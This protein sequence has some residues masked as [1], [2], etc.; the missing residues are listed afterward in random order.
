MY[1]LKMPDKNHAR[2][3]ELMIHTANPTKTNF[4]VKIYVR[5]IL[6]FLGNQIFCILLQQKNKMWGI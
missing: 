3:T 1:I 6:L 5:K 2:D 4:I